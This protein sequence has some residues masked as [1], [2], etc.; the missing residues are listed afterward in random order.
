MSSSFF[1][2]Y[3]II[4]NLAIHYPPVGRQKSL[5]EISAFLKW[6]GLSPPDLRSRNLISV[7]KTEPIVE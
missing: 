6:Y 2:L 4:E 1:A 7:G 3:D 5:T